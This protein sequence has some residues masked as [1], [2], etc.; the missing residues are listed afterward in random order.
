MKQNGKSV[1]IIPEN[2]TGFEDY[3]ILTITYLHYY[4]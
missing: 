2:K 1:D 4:P 3:L